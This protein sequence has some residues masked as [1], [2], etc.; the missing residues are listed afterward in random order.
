MMP[1][2]H[3][4][5]AILV[6]VAMFYGFA[7]GRAQDEAGGEAVEAEVAAGVDEKR[8]DAGAA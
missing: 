1:P 2:P 4:A 7:R 6:A 5:I 3:A 8:G